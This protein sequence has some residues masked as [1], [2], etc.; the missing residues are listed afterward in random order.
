[1]KKIAFHPVGL[2]AILTIVAATTAVGSATVAFKKGYERGNFEGQHDTV[3]KTA[4]ALMIL[5]NAGIT[6][7]QSDGA[8]KRYILTP[9]ETALR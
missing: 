3:R 5:M 6:V 1:M 2:V 8:D 9:V 4:S 7:R